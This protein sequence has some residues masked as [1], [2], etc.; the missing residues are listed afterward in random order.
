MHDLLADAWGEWIECMVIDGNCDRP[1]AKAAN[2]LDGIG[3]AVGAK[4]VGIV[5]KEHQVK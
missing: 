5:A 4:A 2:H 1:I 3:Q